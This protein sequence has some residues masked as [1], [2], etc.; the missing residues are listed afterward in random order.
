[1]NIPLSPHSMRMSGPV[2][3]WQEAVPVGNGILGALIFG[4]PRDELIQTNHCRLFEEPERIPAPDMADLVPK[5]REGLLAGNRRDAEQAW[6]EQWYKRLEKKA[7]LGCFLPGPILQLHTET[8]GMCTRYSHV[9]DFSTGVDTLSF[10]DGPHAV[11]RRIFASRADEALIVEIRLERPTDLTLSVETGCKDDGELFC[12]AVEDGALFSME[13][14]TYALSGAL[15]LLHSHCEHAAWADGTCT[16]K[17]ATY[18]LFAYTMEPTG[19]KAA[20]CYAHLQTLSADY[21]TLISRHTALHQPLMDQMTLSVNGI[22]SKPW[23]NEHLL[24][25]LDDPDMLDA[26]LLRLFHFGRYLLISSCR[27]GGMP[28]NLQGIWNGKR[29]PPW[30]SD[31]HNDINIQMNFW[32]APASGLNEMSLSLFDYYESL[33][34]DFQDNARRVY[35]NRGILMSVSQTLCGY[36]SSNRDVWPCWTGGAAWISQHFFDY[37]RFTDDDTFLRDRALPFM[38]EAALFYED[39][40]DISGEKA[41]FVPSISPENFPRDGQISIFG[42]N[43]TMDFMLARELFTNLITGCRHLGIW[44]EDVARWEHFLTKLPDYETDPETGC[45]REWMYPGLGEN[46]QHRHLSHLYGLFPGSEISP[47]HPMYEACRISLNQRMEVGL[48]SQSGW[49]L[50]QTACLRARLGEGD[51]AFEAVELLA[52]SCV[53]RNL[54]TCHNDWRSQGNTLWGGHPYLQYRGG[55]WGGKAPFQIDANFCVP[56]AIMNMLMQVHG[57]QVQILPALPSHWKRGQICG[58]C[59]PHN[60]RADITWNDGSVSVTLHGEHAGMYTLS[61]P[62]EL[63]VQILPS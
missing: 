2:L 48:N 35:G 14:D 56:T 41:L 59:L 9:L 20:A 50:G 32:L 44:E 51:K 39:F 13:P 60:V 26:L 54:F 5:L 18:A 43:A 55:N 16:V 29:V 62:L 47:E 34:P 19:D 27:P 4:H 17:G 10:H 57:N 42:V 61:S 46:H 24:E 30:D 31:F 28:P 25:S 23:S 8:A 40:V 36:A 63:R 38:R 22:D 58:L 53:G 1:M 52:R 33:V 12:K 45:L 11:S 15:R 7:R 6:K 3:R 21:E 37:W 49:G